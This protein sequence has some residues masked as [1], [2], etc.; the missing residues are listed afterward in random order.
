M[1]PLLS[2]LGF[3]S[4]FYVLLLPLVLVQ[5]FAIIFIP[6]LLVPGAK[7][8]AVGKAVYSYAMQ[9]VGILLMTLG[10]V[11]AIHGV[12]E[13]LVLPEE[14]YT[15][16]I[17]IALLVLFATGGL[18]FLWHE[19]MAQTID[20]A[21]RKVTGVLFWFLWR[22]IG[23]MVVV[24]SLLSLLLTMLLSTPP[25]IEGW[26]TMPL[27]L[28]AYGAFLCAATRPPKTSMNGA[29]AFPRVAMSTA[30]P[31]AKKKKVAEIKL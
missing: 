10:A 18:A 29:A 14:R 21:S 24:V 23:C 13:S 11:P 20:D 19:Q 3:M 8:M 25:L 9:T 30:K 17:Y 31:A 27:V 7:P 5:L 26:W 15:T 16:E 12:L 1:T 22:T 4:V 2:G 28:L 6:S